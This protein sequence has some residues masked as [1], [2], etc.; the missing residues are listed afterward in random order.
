ME[1]RELKKKG[2]QALRQQ[3]WDGIQ[4]QGVNKHGKSPWEGGEIGG[5]SDNE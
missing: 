1:D 2:W 5:S 3:T 4:L